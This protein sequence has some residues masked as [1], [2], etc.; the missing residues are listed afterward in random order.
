MSGTGTMTGLVD[1]RTVGKLEQF[2]GRPDRW[3]DWSFKARAWFGLLPESGGVV[4]ETLLDAAEEREDPI[5]GETLSE[6]QVR[7]ARLVYNVLAQVC[8]GRALSVV[9]N[10]ER[11]NGL[12]CWRRLVREYE[13]ASGARWSAM[14]AGI[15]SPEGWEQLGP[16]RASSR[17]H[18][19][20]GRRASR[21]TRRAPVRRSARRS[22]S[23]SFNA[24]RRGRSERHCERTWR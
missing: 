22:R 19:W 15:L 23:P 18:S 7:L 14:L 6:D 11:G 12:E 13:P 1:T 9:R 16:D 3:G 4:V 20:T 24:S 21:D 8:T 2:D 5:K 17:M 10:V